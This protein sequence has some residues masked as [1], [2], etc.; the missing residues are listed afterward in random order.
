MTHFTELD[1]SVSDKGKRSLRLLKAHC[2]GGRYIPSPQI[3]ASSIREIEFIEA[4][5]NF[6]QGIYVVVTKLETIITKARDDELAHAKQL[7]KSIEYTND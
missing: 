3:S 7:N 4:E 6:P 5:S 1:D 2:F